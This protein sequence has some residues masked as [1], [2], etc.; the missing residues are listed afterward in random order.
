[1]PDPEGLD[2]VAE[3]DAH[4]ENLRQHPELWHNAPAELAKPAGAS[5]RPVPLDPAGPPAG[6]HSLGMSLSSV[7]DL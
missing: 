2:P 6:P 3:L 5:R 4:E 7:E 1:M